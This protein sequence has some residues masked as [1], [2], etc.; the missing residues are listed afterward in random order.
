MQSAA[1]QRLETLLQ[2]R[3]LDR[4]L[5]SGAVGGPAW[6]RVLPTGLEPLDT[7][8]GGGWRQG[9]ISE[10][11]GGRSSGRTSLLVASLTA[12]TRRGGVVGLVDAFDRFDPR[13][14]A[15]AGLD[16]SR[17]LWVR[18][19]CLTVEGRLESGACAP[20]AIR[21]A[22]R[23]FDLIVRAGG[24][25]VAALDF[26]DVPAAWLRALPFTTW[27]R[28]AHANEGRDTVGLLIADAPIGKSA[29]GMSVRLQTSARWTGGSPQAR[30]FAGMTIH[31]NVVGAH[32]AP[33]SPH[34]APRT[35]H[36]AP[37]SHVLLSGS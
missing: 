15:A 12:A 3:R 20:Q 36:S 22:L 18:G 30:R 35:A 28:V 6:T 34:V 25:A 19:P 32:A 21:N 16:L 24:F 37:N 7:A 5:T 27:M 29:H 1:I 8:L 9:E 26:G 11:I 31:L 23:A 33:R 4:T 14:A 10:L 17:V 2:G 13:L